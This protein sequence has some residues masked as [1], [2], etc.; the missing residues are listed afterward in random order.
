M[1]MRAA[2]ES[3]WLRLPANTRGVVWILLY[4]ATFACA[5]GFAKSLARDLPVVEIACIRYVLSLVLIVPVVMHLGWGCLA[6]R[7]PAMHVTRALLSNLS[8]ILVYYAL[9]RMALADATA[10]TF[11]R[12]LFVV[13]LAML[14]LGERVSWQRGLATAIGFTGVLFLVPVSGPSVDL[15]ALSALASALIF[16]SVLVMVRIYAD[17]E[18]PIKFVFYYHAIGAVVFAVPTA[19]AWQAP[20]WQQLGVIA[21]IAVFATAA[22][23]FGI[24][25]YHVAMAS[26]IGPF[27]Y[28][29]LLFAAAFGLVAFG[30]LPDA[31]GLV[32]IAI[33]VACT[34]Y[35]SRRQAAEAEARRRAGA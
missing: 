11:T 28:S 4:C 18:A 7:R 9:T 1:A 21:L 14:V 33:I 13:V 22:Q 10:I 6:T 20:T 17:T 12:P 24:R 30:E 26:V 29:R 15:G 35:N 19:L 34:L 8:Q 5:D 25:A 23:T 2:V 3:A 31:I 27:E 32:G 16:A